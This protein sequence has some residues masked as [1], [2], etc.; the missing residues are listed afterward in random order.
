MPA[1]LFGLDCFNAPM[2]LTAGAVAREFAASLDPAL[3]SAGCPVEVYKLQ[4]VAPDAPLAASD[5]VICRLPAWRFDLAS[6]EELHRQ[7]EELR[8][9]H[10]NLHGQYARTKEAFLS[11][12]ASVEAGEMDA[13]RSA[14]A[15]LTIS[16]SPSSDASSQELPRLRQALA[17][18][19]KKQLETKATVMALR[20]EFMHL[21]DMM[22]D[23]GAAGEG[24]KCSPME[25]PSAMKENARSPLASQ[26][27]KL[28]GGDQQPESAKP[29]RHVSQPPVAPGVRR[30]AGSPRTYR[31]PGAFATP[32]P[33]P[34]ARPR[35]V[36]QRSGHSAGASLRQRL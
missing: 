24:G 14:T 8:V 33:R 4:R 34:A 31:A 26:P 18:S 10:D 25:F 17:L 32:T 29:T 22:S 7:L 19:E 12:N 20:S 9:E 23:A 15:G 16:A 36:H 21:V 5:F 11:L 35:G 2:L 30:P 1:V 3:N 28:T 27:E 6:L 13:K